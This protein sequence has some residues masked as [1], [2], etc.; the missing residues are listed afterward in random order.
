MAWAAARSLPRSSMMIASR[1]P[2]AF[3]PE[4]F[5]PALDVGVTRVTI[6]ISS[7]GTP[8]WR[9]LKCSSSPVWVGGSCVR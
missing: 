7:V 2:A 6:S 4:F 5:A 8:E 1:A 9:S 3:P